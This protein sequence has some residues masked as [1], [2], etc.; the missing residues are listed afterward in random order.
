[1]TSLL[2]S[3]PRLIGFRWQ[4]EQAWQVAAGG[5]LQQQQGLT[6]QEC[7]RERSSPNVA[8]NGHVFSV[9][10][11]SSLAAG[12]KKKRMRRTAAEEATT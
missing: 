7:L 6:V 9:M 2:L 11:G 4:E 8:I 10:V 12:Q 1:M 5:G 3:A